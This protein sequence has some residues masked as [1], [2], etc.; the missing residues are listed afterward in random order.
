MKARI[1]VQNTGRE[2][3]IQ[4]C[5]NSIHNSQRLMNGTNGNCVDRYIT[6]E[7]VILLNFSVPYPTTPPMCDQGSDPIDSS[8]SITDYPNVT[9]SH[10]PESNTSSSQMSKVNNERDSLIISLGILAGILVILLVVVTSGWLWTCWTMKRNKATTPEHV[11]Y[12]K[13]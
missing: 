5:V 4:P 13:R 2:I 8:T 3:Y 1:C 10:K 7:E 6:C 12:K 9:I 11:R